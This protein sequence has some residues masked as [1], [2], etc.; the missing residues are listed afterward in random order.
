MPEDSATARRKDAHLD[1]C[2]AEEV[3]PPEND[4]LLSEAHLVHCALP[5]MA[6]ADVDP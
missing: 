1:L 5:E 2:A 3:A 6:L 4:T